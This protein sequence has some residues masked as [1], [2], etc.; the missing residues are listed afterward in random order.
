MIA[1]QFKFLD[2]SRNF[3]NHVYKIFEC[4]KIFTNTGTPSITLFFGPIKN[5]PV[6]GKTVLME[7]LFST[8]WKN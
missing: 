2:K 1:V 3:S 6:M 5:Y 8:K 7:D 4:N